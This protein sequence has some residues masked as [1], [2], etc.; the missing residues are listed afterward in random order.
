[1][2][3]CNKNNCE[4]CPCVKKCNFFKGPHCNTTIHLNTEMD[5]TSENVVYCIQCTKCSNIYIG[6]TTR[7]LKERFGEHRSSVNTKKVNSVGEHFNGPGHSLAHMSIF[8]LEKVFCSDQEILEKRESYY[9][10]ILQAE[11][12]GI[13]RKCLTQCVPHLT[14]HYELMPSLT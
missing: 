9:I 8:A 7:M 2:K 3:P 14:H 5:C 4:T 10:N 11:F 1:M 6:C 12:K 13:N